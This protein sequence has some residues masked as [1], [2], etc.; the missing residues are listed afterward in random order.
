MKIQVK[1]GN[2]KEAI[3]VVEKYRDDL[4]GRCRVFLQKLAELGLE[5]ADVRFSSAQYDGTNDVKCSIVW[6]DDNHLRVVAAGGAVTFIEFGTG[7]YYPEQHP[8]ADQKGAVRGGYGQGK[9]SQRTWGYYG[10]PGTNGLERTRGDTTVILTHGNPPSRAMYEASKTM[11][12]Q[13]MVIA[14]EVFST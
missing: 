3:R 4:P 14:R 9:G 8:L 11:R 1:L 13:I 2:L 6:D 12:E 5:T 7:V 10:E